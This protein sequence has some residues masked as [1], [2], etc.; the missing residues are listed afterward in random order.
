MHDVGK[1]DLLIAHPPCTY[2]SNVATRQYSLKC[3]WAEKVIARW[4][5]R[6]KAAV[7]F[8]QFAAADC[9]RIAIENPVGVM[10]TH[11]RKPDQTVH[12]YMFGAVDLLLMLY[13]DYAVIPYSNKNLHEYMGCFDGNISI[14]P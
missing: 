14:V 7:F 6:A 11:F 10:S 8:M 4:Q 3:C 5:E 13:L 2:L 12:P 1:W 9:Q